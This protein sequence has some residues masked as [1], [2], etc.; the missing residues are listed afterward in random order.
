MK[1]IYMNMLARSDVILFYH[2][3]PFTSVHL[4]LIVHD[5]TLDKSISYSESHARGLMY[6][7]TMYT[8]LCI[9]IRY[10]Q[11]FSSSVANS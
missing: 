9:K 4:L 3:T 6:K 7:F 10:I 5:S 1:N 11:N 2:D 8:S